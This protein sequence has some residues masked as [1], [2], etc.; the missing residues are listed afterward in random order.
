MQTPITCKSHGTQALRV[1][2]ERVRMGNV[3][4]V[5]VTVHCGLCA[6]EGLCLCGCK[7]KPAF[8]QDMRQPEG[9]NP[10]PLELRSPEPKQGQLV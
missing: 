4:Q 2:R 10:P 8:G 6:A 5:L 9:F 3:S 1:Y 7:D